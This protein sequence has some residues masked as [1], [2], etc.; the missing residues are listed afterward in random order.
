MRSTNCWWRAGRSMGRLLSMKP[1]E[2]LDSLRSQKGVKLD[3]L[4]ASSGLYAL[5][6][7]LSEIRYIGIADTEGFRTRIYNKHTTGSEDRSHKFSCAYNVGRMWRNRHADHGADAKVAKDLRTAFIRRHC[8]ASFVPIDGYD[9]RQALEKI[10]RAV[11]ALATTSELTWCKG[12]RPTEE[13][14]ELVDQIIAKQRLTASE[15]GAI[16]RQNLRFKDNA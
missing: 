10:E 11:Q 1:A 13:P 2:I 5:R 12:F 9:G 6:D 7:H 15:L 4:P 14:T 8:S 3:G 16:H